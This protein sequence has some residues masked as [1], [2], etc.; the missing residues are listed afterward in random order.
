MRKITKLTILTFCLAGLCACARE[1]GRTPE[2]LA[3]SAESAVISSE[4]SNLTISSFAQDY[5][6]YIW[7]GTFR[8]LNKYNS[9]DYHQYFVGEAENTLPDNQINDIYNDSQSRLWVT[10]V[11]GV[12]LCTPQ[13][14]FRRIPS[15]VWNKNGYQFV[16]NSKGRIFLNHIFQLSSYNEE[17]DMFVLV[18]GNLD[19]DIT[20]SVKLH[21]DRHDKLWVANPLYLR[22]YDSETM[23]LRDSIPLSGYP[24]NSFLLDNGEMWLTGSGTVQIMDVATKEFL[25]APQCIVDNPLI[26]DTNI[27][28]VHPYGGGLLLNTEKL[29]L[30]F[31]DPVEGKVFRAGE[32]GF[33]F[34]AP[35]FKIKKMFTDKDGNLW[36]GSE[37]QGY[38]VIYSSF[39]K[40]N[41]NRTLEVAFRNKSVTSLQVDRLGR[42]WVATLID[43]L[44]VCESDLREINKVELPPLPHMKWYGPKINC[45]FVDRNGSLWIVAEDRMV[46]RCS[47]KEGRLVAEETLDIPLARYITQD[48]YGT[49]WISCSSWNI[50][51]RKSGRSEFERIEAFPH[52]FVFVP[53]LLPLRGGQIL[54]A[55]FG[56]N[57][58]MIDPVS[59]KV[60]NLPVSEEDYR[61]CITRSAIIP[62]TMFHDSYGE[63]WIGTITN[64]LLKYSP[65]KNRLVPMEG[66][67]CSDVSSIEEDQHGNIWVSSLFGLSEYDRATGKFT[68]WYST[69]GIGG[70]QFQE[71]SSCRLSDG[72]LVFGGTHGLTFFY[73]EEVKVKREVPL[74]FEDLKI[75]N[76]SVEPGEGSNIKKHLSLLPDIVLKHS[77]KGFG[78]SF[79]ALNYGEYQ[80]VRYSYM[81]DGF[82]NY[83]IE[84]GSVRE[85]NYANLPAGKY[86]FRVRITDNDKSIVETESSIRVIVK[87]AWWAT[88]WAYSLYLLIV[89]AILYTLQRVKHRIAREQEA[90]RFARMEKE[91]EQKVNKMNMSFFANVSHEFRTPLSLISAP[92]AQLCEDPTITGSNKKLLEI[93]Q[94]SVDRMMG[95]V[96][97]LLDFNRLEE[98]SLKL[99][100]K[101]CDVISEM[102]QNMETYRV[103]MEEKGLRLVTYG[104]EDTFFMY[105]DVDKIDKIMANLLSN[106]L[107]FTPAGGTVEV[108]FDVVSQKEA[109]GE[110]NLG[111]KDVDEQWIKLVVADSGPGIPEDKLEKVFERYYQL[112]GANSGNYNYG[113]GIGLYYARRLAEMHHGYLKAGRR[114]GAEA[115]K[116]S[117]ASGAVFTLILPAGDASYS[118]EEYD[119]GVQSQ[120]EAYPLDIETKGGGATGSPVGAGEGLI[121]AGGGIVASGEGLIQADG[122][123]VEADGNAEAGTD[124]QKPCILVVDDDADVV[125]YTKTL[126]SDRYRVI[127]RF[128]ADSA[129]ETLEKEIPDLILCDV[130]MPRKSGYEFCR[131]VK[132]NLQICHIPVILL[133]AKAAVRDQ[134]EGLDSGADAYVTKPFD[135]S[136]LL[137]L[138]N[139]QLKNRE[140]VRA[141]LNRTTQADE[142]EENTLSPQ[143]KAF[144]SDLYKL[145][146]AELTNSELNVVGV[147]EQLHISRTKIYY[148]VK[149]L[150][151]ESPSNF[152]KMYKLNRA[153]ELLRDGH[154]TISEVADLTGFSTL[155]YF[156][157]SFKKHFG[158]PPSE[159]GK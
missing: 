51:Y 34:D 132:S 62:V 133:T 150:T 128:G 14:D 143:D 38:D 44:Y 103:G 39:N 82:D 157:T 54:A 123:A 102:S 2:R 77:Q 87:P 18:N 5:F 119:A 52:S 61:S 89:L 6:G 28:I 124:D 58:K 86:T 59:G 145:M 95:L 76:R 32:D 71:R 21:V 56:N 131:E 144:I 122:S 93:V 29:G 151:G 35:E 127:C 117:A 107:K 115:G 11:N 30:F 75:Y 57:I 146:E 41:N 67:A 70:N 50:Y 79:A 66:V 149:A 37:D 33:P 36:I 15:E 90:A 108:S 125:Y 97:Q 139:T 99:K 8:G 72:L 12:A 110:F 4:I 19:P 73:P 98:D 134:V 156:S 141:L 118:P 64:G 48:E 83:W 116:G 45:L 63:V 112:D 100:V 78:I 91:Q 135:P 10:T 22:S 53:C 42:L 55:A 142:I 114:G 74:R 23:E 147:A 159:Y 7:I 113:S 96:N 81:L 65:S 109:A 130:A 88:W 17:K 27:N 111:A 46:M 121:Q 31:Y 69:D 138:I 152:F 153:A 136:F 3:D 92:V 1:R 26:A 80:R 106:A 158:V 148:K 94:R 140:K 43:G 47:Y 154:Y 40:F 9:Y 104:L 101:R 137:A 85:A 49:M 84:F 105:A 155:S 20:M 129:L 126:L 16:E 24:Y 68:N 120:Q 60:S 13:G 25:P